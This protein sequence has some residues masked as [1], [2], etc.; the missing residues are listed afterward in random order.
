MQRC[1]WGNCMLLWWWRWWVSRFYRCYL[2]PK[3][4]WTLIFPSCNSSLEYMRRPQLQCY[5]GYL[6]TE[7]DNVPRFELTSCGY[8]DKYVCSKSTETDDS[9][10]VGK[11]CISRS[12][13]QEGAAVGSCIDN[14]FTHTCY[15]DTDGLVDNITFNGASR[16]RENCKNSIIKS[17][18]FRCNAAETITRSV[19][20]FFFIILIVNLSFL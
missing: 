19:H 20:V 14:G 17:F 11:Q 9:P 1:K 13:M 5:S 2:K 4:F 7:G 10:D 6:S 12:S 18:V 3:H 15:C 16:K 8:Q